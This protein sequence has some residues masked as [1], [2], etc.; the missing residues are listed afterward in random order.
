[1]KQWGNVLVHRNEV[2]RLGRFQGSGNSVSPA[3]FIS[4]SL[5]ASFPFCV[6]QLHP[7][8]GGDLARAIWDLTFTPNHVQR[9][10]KVICLNRLSSAFN[11]SQLLVIQHWKLFAF[12]YLMPEKLCLW[13]SLTSWVVNRLNEIM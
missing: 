11:E 13:G 1:M 7:L 10:L 2:Q 6:C 9:T 4:S 8:L 5:E 3:P 12:N